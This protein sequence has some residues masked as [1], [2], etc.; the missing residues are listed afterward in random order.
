MTPKHIRWKPE[1]GELALRI[2]G[3][4][5]PTTL[6]AISP[7]LRSDT[8]QELCMGNITITAA[9]VYLTDEELED[10]LNLN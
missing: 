1:F 2:K 6:D 5:V 4:I 7:Y 3:G 10:V 9:N 8:I